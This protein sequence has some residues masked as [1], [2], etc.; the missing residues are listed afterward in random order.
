[1]TYKLK[2]NCKNVYSI[3]I[4]IA[5]RYWNRGYGQDSINLLLNHLFND[6]WTIRIELD[7]MKSN[8]RAVTCYKKCLFIEKS[9]NRLRGYLDREYVDTINMGILKEEF[10]EKRLKKKG[11]VK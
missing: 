9:I 11:A 4:T 1:M 6:L 3:G 2:K 7:V 10:N 5:S 8:I